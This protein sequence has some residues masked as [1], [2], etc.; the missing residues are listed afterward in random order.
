[1]CNLWFAS[2]NRATFPWLQSCMMQFH[3]VS[4]LHSTQAISK[5]PIP[6]RQTTFSHVLI[7]MMFSY[8]YSVGWSLMI[9]YILCF[10]WEF[11][12]ETGRWSPKSKDLRSKST[13]YSF[14]SVLSVFCYIRWKPPNLAIK[15][16]DCIVWYLQYVKLRNWFSHL[17]KM[18]FFIFIL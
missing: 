4:H 10:T 9:R 18:D 13:F 17:K 11:W 14:S 2:E 7:Q 15:G 16:F 1:M 6:R 5:S 12:R 8:I 3:L